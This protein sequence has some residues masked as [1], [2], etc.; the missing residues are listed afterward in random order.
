M[1][2]SSVQVSPAS[3]YSAADDDAPSPTAVAALERLPHQL[4][5]AH[6]LERVVGAAAGE[7]H[8]VRHQIAVDAA[9]IDEVREPELARHRLALIVEIDADDLVGAGDPR[10][11][12]DVEAD[13]AQPEDHHV[14]ARL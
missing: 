13:A 5:V 8:Q 7:L 3:Q 11:L 9:R 10:A 2:V 1:K 4:D 6:A 12:H 14:G